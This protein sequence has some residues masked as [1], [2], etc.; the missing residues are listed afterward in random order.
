MSEL[1]PSSDAHGGSGGL[2]DVAELILDR[3]LMIGAFVRVS[4]VGIELLTI[5]ARV[6]AASVDAYLRFADAC[7]RIDLTLGPER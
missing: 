1:T 6:V 7:N 3:G 4:L 2:Y 5:D